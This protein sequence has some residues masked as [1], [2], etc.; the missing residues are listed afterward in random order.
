[1]HHFPNGNIQQEIHKFFEEEELDAHNV[2][3]DTFCQSP[4]IQEENAKAILTSKRLNNSDALSETLKILT[5]KNSGYY[6]SD[7]ND[8]EGDPERYPKVGTHINDGNKRKVADTS[9]GNLQQKLLSNRTLPIITTTIDPW[10]PDGFT[11]CGGTP[12]AHPTPTTKVFITYMVRSSARVLRTPGHLSRTVREG[13]TPRNCKTYIISPRMNSPILIVGNTA[14]PTC[15]I[16]GSQKIISI[17]GSTGSVEVRDTQ[18]FN[19][20]IDGNLA[21]DGDST[22]IFSNLIGQ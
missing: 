21:K 20:S 2:T 3:A 8:A 7:E 1:M 16:M 13:T 12:H 19:T 5:I 10:I 22:S 6:N 17:H 9:N 11:T 15:D 14:S 4:V 18:K